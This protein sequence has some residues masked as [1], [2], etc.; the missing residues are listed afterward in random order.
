MQIVKEI[1]ID[2]IHQ[3]VN[4]GCINVAEI[5]TNHS[6]SF[7]KFKDN[8]VRNLYFPKIVEIGELDLDAGKFYFHGWKGKQQL[9]Q[10]DLTS[11]IAEFET[12]GKFNLSQFTQ[13]QQAN[14]GAMKALLF[15]YCG[16]NNIHGRVEIAPNGD[17][18][19]IPDETFTEDFVCDLDRFVE[20]VMGTE[21][22]SMGKKG[23]G[24]AR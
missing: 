13:K 2:V 16:A 17:Y 7:Q 15:R 9:S 5:C 8:Y 10:K 11:I 14:I 20:K 4:Q 12:L 22:T 6:L 1:V 24:K 23:G 21:F 18:I 19:V 3:S